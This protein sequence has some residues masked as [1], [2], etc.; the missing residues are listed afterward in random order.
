MNLGPGEAAG[1]AVGGFMNI[2]QSQPLSLAL[3]VMNLSLLG[4]FWFIT[5]KNAE[6]RK[7][8]TAMIYEDHKQVRDLLA[9]CVI[10]P[11]LPN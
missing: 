7:S 2:M 9:R 11:S 6:T 4:L 10:P 8:E 5:D 3:V 1:K